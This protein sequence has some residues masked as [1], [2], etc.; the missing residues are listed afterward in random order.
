MKGQD[1]LP[2]LQKYP[3]IP[4]YEALL[5]RKEGTYRKIKKKKRRRR[6]RKKRKEKKTTTLHEVD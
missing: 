4:R 5:E 2:W 3:A 6:R 1:A